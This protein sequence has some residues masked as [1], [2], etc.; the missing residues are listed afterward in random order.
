MK[1]WKS[2]AFTVVGKSG[3]TPNFAATMIWL[4]NRNCFLISSGKFQQVWNLILMTFFQLNISEN[5]QNVDEFL[6]HQQY[7]HDAPADRRPV[8]GYWISCANFSNANSKGLMP[9]SS[10]SM[11]R[12]K[13]LNFSCFFFPFEPSQL[14]KITQL[15]NVAWKYWDSGIAGNWWDP[16]RLPASMKFLFF[17]V[18][19]VSF[20]NFSLL[21]ACWLE[22]RSFWK[23]YWLQFISYCRGSSLNKSRQCF[24]G[25]ERA[26]ML[27]RTRKQITT[28]AFDFCKDWTMVAQALDWVRTWHLALE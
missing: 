24:T 10:K 25:K 5:N 16:V 11:P 22:L 7:Y 26:H 14:Q 13:R 18:P 8:T 3:A 28:N 15:E 12:P 21:P 6:P 9:W 20:V 4:Y 1:L 27:S 2:W 19:R 17:E 23:A